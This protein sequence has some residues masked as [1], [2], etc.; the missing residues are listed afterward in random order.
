LPLGPYSRLAARFIRNVDGGRDG[1]K[2]RSLSRGIFFFNL[3]TGDSDRGT[4]VGKRFRISEVPLWE[5]TCYERGTHVGR[6]SLQGRR[7][8]INE[9]GTP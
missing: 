1:D 9:R 7:C 5:V 8:L 4:F 6:Q 3:R 2:K